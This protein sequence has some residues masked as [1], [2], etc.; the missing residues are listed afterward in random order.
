MTS[1]VTFNDLFHQFGISVDA[2]GTIQDIHKYASMYGGALVIYDMR[3]NMDGYDDDPFRMSYRLSKPPF[4]FM[5]YGIHLTEDEYETQK[6]AWN[7][8]VVVNVEPGCNL[9]LIDNSYLLLR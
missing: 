7:G 1:R 5:I 6:M 3:K 9:T 2:K 8:E 4:D